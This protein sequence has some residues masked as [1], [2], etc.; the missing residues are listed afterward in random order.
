MTAVW[1]R[2]YNPCMT[3]TH[4][5]QSP[6]P[7]SI[8]DVFLGHLGAGDFSA[9]A[10]LFE[11]DVSLRALLPYGLREW[12]GPEA[13]EAAFVGWFGRVDEYELLATGIDHVGPRMRLQW[14]ARVRGGSFGDAAHIVEQQ[15]YADAGA[16]G[17]IGHLSMLCS[18]F[19]REA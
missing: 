17:R 7:V 8:A 16:T 4:I 15:V 5:P 18:G 6:H 12:H 14:R 13:V 10:R 3:T 1:P 9:L 19:A 11:P 2:P